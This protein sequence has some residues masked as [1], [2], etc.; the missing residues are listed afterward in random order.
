[1]WRK[2]RLVSD[3]VDLLLN[4]P[5][6]AGDDARLFFKD[7]SQDLAHPL[8]PEVVA[9]WGEDGPQ[10]LSVSD[11]L[12]DYSLHEPSITSPEE[13]DD[14]NESPAEGS[15]CVVN[16]VRRY[17]SLHPHERANMS[18]VLFNCDSARLPQAVVD[19]IGSI[20]DDDEDIRCQV[21]LRHVASERL[22]DL[23]HSILGATTTSDT[24]SAS[25]ATED[26]MARLR[27]S[28]I[29]DQAPPPDPKDGCPYDIVFSQ[30]VISRHAK[31]EWHKEDASPADITSLLPSRWSRRR[32][33]A[34]DDLK[35]S[36][37][38]CCPVQS[39][40][41][42]SY[43]SAVASL[44]RGDWDGDK[45]RRLLPVRQLDFRDG[46]TARIFEETHNLGNWVVNFDELLDRR[47]LLNQ[48]VRIIRYKQSATQG[49]NV[50]ISSR[51]PLS[52]LRSM[53]L[54]PLRALNLE[55]T[56]EE[57]GLLAER[58]INDANDVSGDIVLRAAKRGQSASE[59]IGVVLSRA[60]IKDE[61]G[62]GRAVGWYFLDDYAAWMGQREEQ[63]ADLLTLSPEVSPDGTLRLTIIVAEAKYIDDAS[64]AAKR[65]ES[66]KQLRDTMHR[67]SEAIFGNP[68]RLDRESWLARIADLVL[69][70]IRL[71]AASGIDL[72]AWRRAIREGRC[73]IH[74]R[75]YSHVFVPTS[76]EGTDRTDAY[77]VPSLAGGYQEVYGR[78]ALKQLLRAYWLKQSPRDIRIGAGADYLAEEPVWQ[79]PGSG[80]LSTS[81]TPP[82]PRQKKREP[83]AKI[84]EE[85]VASKPNAAPEIPA[86][87]S[88][89]LRE[90]LGEVRVSV[91]D[92][93]AYPSIQKLL[94]VSTVDDVP[95]G[96]E[97][98]LLKISS[99]A[100]AALQQMNLQ[101]KL[102]SSS[103]TPNSAL[104]R[105][106][107]S[108]NLTVDQVLKRRSELLTTFGLNVI[109][110][111][112]EPGAV[113][114]AIEREV[115]QVVDIRKVWTRWD[116]KKDGW[117]NQD[118]LIGVAESDGSLLFLSP[119]RAHAPHTLIAGSTGSGKSV[120]V[121]NILLAIAATNI[122]QQA[123]I[124]LIDPKQGVD[125]FAFEGMAHLDGGIIDEQQ[126]ASQRLA[127]LV[128]EM[129]RRY[130]RFKEKRVANIT[131]YNAK[132]PED[133]RLPVIWLVHDEFAEWMLIDE[134]KDAVSTVVQRLGIKARAAGIYLVFAAQRPDA[135]VMPMQL[136]ANLGNRLILRVDS[137][138]TS[139]IALGERGAERLLGR[140]HLLAK[141]EGE[142]HLCFA[143]V[144]YV[145]S[146]FIDRVVQITR[147]NA[148]RRGLV[149]A[150]P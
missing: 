50:I 85:A 27:I 140:G 41:G 121:Q 118:L 29:A 148:S 106:A 123:R 2:A 23:Y 35:S 31:L 77:A 44:F 21:L 17:L 5:G 19:K 145:D 75:G 146:E 116:P 110:V 108:A 95:G 149:A 131:E 53:I 133:E 111:R 84:A 45:D 91:S 112:P 13:G 42:W 150:E 4:T 107:G 39:G 143:Q 120:L 63:L 22:R 127:E 36:V 83:V 62:A 52:L 122:P 88:D 97:Q 47:Q 105:F 93:W 49:R 104:L 74:L 55:L 60:L 33:A 96:E 64:L 69:D 82:K 129:D 94:T 40:E 11:V 128:L 130:V 113:V 7:I 80:E 12:L 34:A 79:R 144:P 114:I 135:N 43:L 72:A 3:L 67:I 54:H 137:E 18:V 59:L 46:R 78:S 66:Q 8:Y 48:E 71:P 132:S 92:G 70:G 30:D 38:L 115:R 28:V 15:D 37:Y 51:A 98:W 103:L 101:A 109:S 26:F 86:E 73:E 6:T 68:H 25:E 119:G 136:R 142:R 61:L 102:L 124:V 125:Y 56:G 147:Y 16:L 10:V 57:L 134:Y 138:G 76:V 1:M 20:H 58:L 24:Y 141:L 126:T 100:K 87:I 9:T 65:K 32:P 139:E 117:G 90:H 14:T 89:V 99:L 81:P